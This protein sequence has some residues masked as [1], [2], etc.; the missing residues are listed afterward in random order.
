MQLDVRIP[1]GWLF[2]LLGLILCG[3]GIAANPAIYAE[4]SLGRNVNLLWGAVF[5]LFGA[6][7]LLLARKKK[8]KE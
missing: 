7:T 8:G 6:V 3:Y 4:H 1:M 2:L 5:V